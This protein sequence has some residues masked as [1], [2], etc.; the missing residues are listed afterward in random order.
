MSLSS[1]VLLLERQK[2]KLRGRQ[3]GP[4]RPAR[5]KQAGFKGRGYSGPGG[6]MAG[7]WQSGEQPEPKLPGETVGDEEKKRITEFDNQDDWVLSM[8]LVSLMHANPDLTPEQ[9]ILLGK[10]WVK[11]LYMP[12]MEHIW[13]DQTTRLKRY[14][15][16]AEASKIR[17]ELF[18]L[19]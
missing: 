12:R 10:R 11:K 9:A 17:R 16:R 4:R 5:S 19:I 1:V 2:A 18:K 6:R 13:R 14:G 8:I 15:I 3:D 7:Q